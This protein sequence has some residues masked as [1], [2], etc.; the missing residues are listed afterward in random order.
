MLVELNFKISV[1]L[2]ALN[3]SYFAQAQSDLGRKPSEEHTYF[4]IDTLRFRSKKI[5]LLYTLER[6][7]EMDKK[8][9]DLGDAIFSDNANRIARLYITEGYKNTISIP[10][11]PLD[12]AI[13]D[14][15]NK[16]IVGLSRA[17]TSPYKLVLYDFNG[18][19]LFKKSISAFELA[20]DATDYVQFG[21]SFPAFLEY[22][23]RENQVLFEHG[24]YYI[25]LG[26][27]K[28]LS[29]Q[30]KEKIK[31]SSWFKPSHY[32]P[33]LFTEHLDGWASYE[34]SKYTNFYSMTDPFYEFEISESGQPIGIILNDEL[35][36]KVKI[37][38][39]LTMKGNNLM[40]RQLYNEPL[41]DTIKHKTR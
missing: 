5:E 18:R 7:G 23:V 9:R 38:I 12:N 40:H 2:F 27:W 29:G 28:F 11:I 21:K 17:T 3:C 35:G 14:D 8:I 39:P 41:R 1:L 4:S 22:A 34:I 25:D 15:S 10:T 24:L 26:Y 20:M 37:S 6:K 13:I 30:E 16:L 32:F 31:A 19:L 33:Y 36:N